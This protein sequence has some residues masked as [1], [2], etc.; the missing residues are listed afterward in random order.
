MK[1]KTHPKVTLVGAGPGSEYLIGG[2]GLK[3][4]RKAD[5]VPYDALISG[6]LLARISA[7]IPKIYVGK[8]CFVGKRCSE[9][10][11][12]QDD[13]NS[14]GFQGPLSREFPVFNVC[15]FI[16][17]F[18]LKL[19]LLPIPYYISRNPITKIFIRP[20]VPYSRI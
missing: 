6:E 4:L 20:C 7:L 13:I 11:F 19:S 17:A 18:N 2:R 14:L 3:A 5:I 1:S 16:P 15:C 8:P 10:S 9:H 12:T